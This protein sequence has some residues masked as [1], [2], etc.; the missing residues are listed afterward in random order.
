MKPWLAALG[1]IVRGTRIVLALPFLVAAALIMT[2][3]DFEAILGR[4]LM[5]LRARRQ[6]REI[7]KTGRLH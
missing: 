4:V 2:T 1:Q 5:N 3:E 6:D 7:E